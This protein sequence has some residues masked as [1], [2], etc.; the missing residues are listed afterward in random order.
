MYP[1]AKSRP[2]RES[3]MALARARLIDVIAVAKLDRW[4]PVARGP[5]GK[6]AG[7]D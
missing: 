6:H 1:R 4:G 2:M 3:L 7:A 5:G